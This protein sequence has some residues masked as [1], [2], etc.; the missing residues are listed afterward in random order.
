MAAR[1]NGLNLF[2][3]KTDI[4]TLATVV[5]TNHNIA[6]ADVENLPNVL[7]TKANSSV[8]NSQI[9]TV[10]G[11]IALKANS[12]DVTSQISTVNN[13]IALKANSSDVTSQINT[14]NSNLATKAN[15]SDLAS[16]QNVLIRNAT[17]QG[18]PVIDPTNKIR[19]IFGLSPVDVSLYFDPFTPSDPKNNQIQVS[20]DLTDYATLSYV[21]TAIANLVNS[22]PAA[23]N[24]LS[25]LATALGNDANF[26]TT[27]TNLLAT[28]QT[29]IT[30]FS[31]PIL[32]SNNTLS[33]DSTVNN[34]TNYYNKTTSDNNYQA[35]ITAATNLSV[36]YL[37]VNGSLTGTGIT[38]LLNGYALASSIP[39][40]L[41]LSSTL[42][43]STLTVVNGSH[44]LS[45]TGDYAFSYIY[46]NALTGNSRILTDCSAGP[47]YII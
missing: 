34:L 41:S 11:N 5:N 36:N 30:T 35:K 13:N 14:V 6:I 32:Y 38:N 1:Q 39:P 17:A 26:S 31:N 7:A 29:K 12:S 23:L 21:A 42:V 9:T 3:D 16:K 46:D 24:T 44:R 25:E 22:S 28:K 47:E 40:A 15:S 20:I 2:S 45:F 37:I 19:C 43:G 27:I 4:Q 8:V 10:N 33:F 18:S